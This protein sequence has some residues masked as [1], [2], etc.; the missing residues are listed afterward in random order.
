MRPTNS[1]YSD[2]H[3]NVGDSEHPGGMKTYC[4]PAGRYDSK[5]GQLPGDFWSNV[6]FK[7]GKGASG[8]RF[9]QRMF[10]QSTV[11]YPYFVC[12]LR[13]TQLLVVSGLHT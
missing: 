6:E 9:A 4:T 5:Q 3:T 11:L 13:N 2:P 10:S 7:T 8:G 12:L 1:A